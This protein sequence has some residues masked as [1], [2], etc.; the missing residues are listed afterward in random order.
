MD[1]VILAF[2]RKKADRDEQQTYGTGFLPS[3]SGQR[4]VFP[5]CRW[6]FLIRREQTSNWVQILVLKPLPIY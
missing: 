5:G 3:P 2:T 1:K 4:P 6:N